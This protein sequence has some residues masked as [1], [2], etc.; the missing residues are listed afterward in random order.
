MGK[1]WQKKVLDREGGAYI[2]RG[3]RKDCGRRFELW[4]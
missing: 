4:G 1:K 3:A 2:I